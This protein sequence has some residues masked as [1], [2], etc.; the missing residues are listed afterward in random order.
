LYVAIALVLRNLWVWLH[1]A[2]LSRPRRGGIELHLERLR[3]RTMLLWLFEVAAE[4]Y[5]LVNM[6]LIERLLPKSV[7]T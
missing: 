7:T 2:V 4:M 3:L 6:A 1:Y 5:G